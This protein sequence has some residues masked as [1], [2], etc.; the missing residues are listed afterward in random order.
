VGIVAGR[1]VGNAVA[2]NRAKRRLRQAIRQV[3]LQ[4]DTAYVVVA[5]TDTVERPF[6][7]LISGLGRAIVETEE[8]DR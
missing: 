6:E 3:E 4:P 5:S 1:G 7:A 2:R 8:N